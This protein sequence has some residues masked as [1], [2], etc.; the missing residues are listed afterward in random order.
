M[1][2]WEFSDESCPKCG[3]QLAWIN[4][5]DCESGVWEETDCNGTEYN[6]CDNC[7]GRGYHEWC[8]ECGWDHAENMFLSP[9]YAREWME[10]QEKKNL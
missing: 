7:S 9:K 2:D 6:P 4:C 10:K 5:Y 8:R 1:S 3:E